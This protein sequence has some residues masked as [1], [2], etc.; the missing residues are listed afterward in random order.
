MALHFT[1]CE[2]HHLTRAESGCS[3][4]S[5]IADLEARLARA[6]AVPAEPRAPSR[7]TD[8]ALVAWL[9]GVCEV[10]AREGARWRAF[11]LPGD[12][13]HETYTDARGRLFFVGEHLGALERLAVTT[14]ELVLAL[15]PPAPGAAP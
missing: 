7:M 1:G 4:C 12:L 9:E 8:A 15:K 5:F 2:K 3:T 13:K 6:S 10:A 11:R 14:R